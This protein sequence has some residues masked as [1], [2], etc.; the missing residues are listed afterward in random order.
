MLH[1]NFTEH[2][3][4]CDLEKEKRK[5]KTITAS[6]QE[7]DWLFDFHI[8]CQI[9]TR[10]FFLKGQFVLIT[11]NN[12]MQH[13]HSELDFMEFLIKGLMDKKINVSKK[14]IC[15]IKKS[16]TLGDNWKNEALRNQL[17]NQRHDEVNYIYHN[18]AGK[19]YSICTTYDFGTY[20][21]E[22]IDLIDE[23]KKTKKYINENFEH[24]S[25]LERQ[26]DALYNY[27]AVYKLRDSALVVRTIDEL[28]SNIK[29]KIK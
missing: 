7:H 17:F 3:E 8:P 13:L 6:K 19:E 4:K 10:I 23:Y 2:S 9:E 28:I 27:N 12:C 1:Y 11:M 5:Q 20:I 29:N 15:N 24:T 21:S 14:L 26:C 18:A 22:R 16:C 25:V